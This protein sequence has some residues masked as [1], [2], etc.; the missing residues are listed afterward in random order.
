MINETLKNIAFDEMISL[1]PLCSHYNPK[2]VVVIGKAS[3]NL[4]NILNSQKIEATFYENIEKCGVNDVDVVI[5]LGNTIDAFFVAH[6]NKILNDKGLFTTLS[7]NF[8]ENE[9]QLKNDLTLLGESFWIAM[10]YSFCGMTAI[11]ASKKYHPVSDV[12][13]QRS[14]LLDGM[15]YYNSDFHKCSFTYP[16]YIHKGLTNIARR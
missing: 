15:K 14:D 3:E 4:K 9:A 13:L 2:K 16:T 6:L 8:D 11:C 5:N 1:V 7:V 10:P 12:I